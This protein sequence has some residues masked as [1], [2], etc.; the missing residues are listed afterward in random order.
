M[1]TQLY[2]SR[3]RW[4]AAL[5]IALSVF[6]FWWAIGVRLSGAA[7]INDQR[8]RQ[9]A[10][11]FKVTS[12][13]WQR[14]AM[15]T[16]ELVEIRQQARQR[17][18]ADPDGLPA[19]VDKLQDIADAYNISIGVQMTESQPFAQ[20]VGVSTRDLTLSFSGVSYDSLVAYL[21]ALEQQSDTWVF[22]I[23]DASLVSRG[24]DA[25]VKG[26]VKVRFWTT[27]GG[28]SDKEELLF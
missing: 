9:E 7:E 12:L 1:A 18:L 27:V 4:A 15:N 25:Q 17:L 8:M 22:L 20:V 3:S 14:D 21:G 2:M 5:L 6:L 23:R 24:N 26:W 19:L 28:S 16:A 10:L 11:E 13:R